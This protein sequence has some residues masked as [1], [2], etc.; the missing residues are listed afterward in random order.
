M[1]RPAV[2]PISFFPRSRGK[3]KKEDRKGSSDFDGSRDRIFERVFHEPT[4]TAPYLF[5]P[6]V[7][8]K[9][10]KGGRNGKVEKQNG[11]FQRRGVDNWMIGFRNCAI[12]GCFI[13]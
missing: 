6:R 9:M 5:L 1:K 3:M 13:S 12:R 10:K 8:G 7:R 4:P 11:E 2:H